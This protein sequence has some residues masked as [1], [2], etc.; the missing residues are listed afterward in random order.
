MYKNPRFLSIVPKQDSPQDEDPCLQH[1]EYFGDTRHCYRW[2]GTGNSSDRAQGYCKTLNPKA[3]LLTV[4]QD[5]ETDFVLTLIEPFLVRGCWIGIKAAFGWY[6]S[7]HLDY[8]NWADH[9]PAGQTTKP[10]VWMY[11]T[12]ELKGLWKT[13][14][15]EVK[16]AIGIVCK[17]PASV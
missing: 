12:G 4:D 1:W 14:K 8:T 17:M 10:C 9:E 13:D 7:P 3:N 15:C 2:V 6:V 11:G 5:T 16:S